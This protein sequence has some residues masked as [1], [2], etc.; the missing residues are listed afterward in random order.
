MLVY[1]TKGD[2]KDLIC[3]HNNTCNT[4]PMVHASIRFILGH[5]DVLCASKENDARM[6]TLG[7]GVAGIAFY[8]PSQV[9]ADRNIIYQ[10]SVL[11]VG[12]RQ[13]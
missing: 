2:S 10:V 12:P 1:E 9:P 6:G 8:Q 3:R 5:Y 13:T 4:N 7:I 11:N